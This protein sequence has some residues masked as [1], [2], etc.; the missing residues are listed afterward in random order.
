MNLPITPADIAAV[1]ALVQSARER[2]RR[3]WD[4]MVADLT[5][6]EKLYGPHVG[7]PDVEFRVPDDAELLAHVHGE[8]WEARNRIWLEQWRVRDLRGK[9]LVAWATAC[10]AA[11]AAILAWM[12]WGNG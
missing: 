1:E 5:R 6:T 10:V 4:A 3:Q 2:R 8:L 9:L 12:V 11:G 7:A